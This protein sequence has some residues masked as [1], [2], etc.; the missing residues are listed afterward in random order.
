MPQKR[1]VAELV[2]DNKVCVVCLEEI[3]LTNRTARLLLELVSNRSYAFAHKNA[4]GASGGGVSL[5][6]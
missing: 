5:L 6:E 1:M 3:K 2:R 4:R